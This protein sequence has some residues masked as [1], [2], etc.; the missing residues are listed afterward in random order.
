MLKRVEG[1]GAALPIERS[2][3]RVLGVL[4]SEEWLASFV[5]CVRR[6]L[7]LDGVHV[8]DVGLRIVFVRSGL[9]KRASCRSSEAHN[10]ALNV[11]RSW[12]TDL[13]VLREERK[14]R[15]GFGKCYC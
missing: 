8:L 1:A 14:R 12:R 11:L 7:C 3:S 9:M 15:C 5:K 2:L 13:C 4:L 10:G 6:Q